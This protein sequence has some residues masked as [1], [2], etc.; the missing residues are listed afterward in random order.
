MGRFREELERSSRQE[1]VPAAL[2]AVHDFLERRFGDLYGHGDNVSD[3][4]ELTARELGLP[5]ET[6]AGLRV[7]GALH[8][9]GKMAVA[10]AI[11]RKQGPLEH[12][13]WEEVR[14]HTEV[15]A[16]LLVG[17]QLDEIAEWVRA[18]HERM[19]GSGY[20]LGID[21]ERIPLPARVLAVAD[22]YD[23]MR[24][25]R[26]YRPAL[27]HEEAAAE[28]RGGA[29]TQFDASVVEALL[30]ALARASAPAGAV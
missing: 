23:A 1:A 19:D 3:Y 5:E 4:C 28:L 24:T 14:R 15:G 11:L 30:G 21:G 13:E 17:S 18:H 2:L 6:I 10:P 29:G 22:A 26:S 7:A 25:A 20:P 12:K 27:T 16:S 9:L 8:D